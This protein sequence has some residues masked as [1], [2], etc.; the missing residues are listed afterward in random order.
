MAYPYL[1]KA[2]Q[3]PDGWLENLATAALSN[4][5][6]AQKTVFKLQTYDWNKKH[7]LSEAEIRRQ[8]EVLRKKGVIHIAYYPENV[9][10]EQ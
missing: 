5:E 7:W 1:E 4:R 8:T 6:N 3:N 2:Y 10:S 9:Y